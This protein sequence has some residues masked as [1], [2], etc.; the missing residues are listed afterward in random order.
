MMVAPTLALLIPSRLPDKLLVIV[1]QEF[2]PRRFLPVKEIG[3]IVVVVAAHQVFIW[4]HLRKK[5]VTTV[6]REALL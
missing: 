2:G 3:I 5:L 4:P 6:L 1:T